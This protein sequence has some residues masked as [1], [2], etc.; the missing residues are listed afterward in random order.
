MRSRGIVCVFLLVASA[1]SSGDGTGTGADA[2]FPAAPLETLASDDAALDIDIRTSPSQPPQR[3]TCA[4]ELTI[5]NASGTPQDGLALDVVP[6]MP[7]HGHG[8]SSTATVTAKGG[9][10]YVVTDVDFFMPGDWELRTT[11]TGPLAD[12]V[13]PRFSVP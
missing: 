9:G 8:A 11:I 7:A 4:I 6:W 3:G 1:C 12:H 5:T 10:K 13:A 2:G